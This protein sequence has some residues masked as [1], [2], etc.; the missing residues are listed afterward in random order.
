MTSFARSDLNGKI[1]LVTGGTNGIGLVAA[2]ELARMDAHVV[3]VGRSEAKLGDSAR[4][5]KAETGRDVETMKA[6]LEILS[7]VRLLADTFSTRF[8]RLDVLLNNAGAF[9]QRRAETRDGI[10]RTWALNHLAPFVLTT[11]LLPLLERAGDARVVTVSSD[12]HRFGRLHWDDIE[13]RRRYSAWG[14]YGQSKLA[15]IL[16]A[17]ELA[18]RTAG[19]GM[20]S[21]ALHP[22]F[23]RTGFGGGSESSLSGRLLRLMTR[24]AITAEE[25]A[26]TSVY[27]CAS[28]TVHGVSGKYFEKEREAVP[29]PRALDD[30]SARRLWDVSEAMTSV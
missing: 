23:V 10:E 28:P 20:T 16:F 19:T 3:I 24:F 17:R 13:F 7:E 26:R 5:I 18:R 25:G 11:R 4:V 27:L 2:R 15:N 1:A 6:D 12:A 8:D 29:A 22:G 21:N 30:Q 14:A 9:F